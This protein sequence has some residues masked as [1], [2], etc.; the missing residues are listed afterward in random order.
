LI[1]GVYPVL[2]HPFMLYLYELNFTLHL[3]ELKSELPK[4]RPGEVSLTHSSRD[5][6]ETHH[7][8]K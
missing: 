5:D 4:E 2:P 1:G 3:Y 8:V 7:V 6:L